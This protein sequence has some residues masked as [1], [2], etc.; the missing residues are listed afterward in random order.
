[1]NPKNHLKAPNLHPQSC[2]FCICLLLIF[3]ESCSKSTNLI[4]R[5]IK[6]SSQKTNIWANCPIIPNP[7]LFGQ[8]WGLIPLLNHR[9]L[10]WACPETYNLW[11]FCRS[12]KFLNKKRRRT[13]AVSFGSPQLLGRKDQGITQIQWDTTSDLAVG[14][15]SQAPFEFSLGKKNLGKRANSLH[16]KMGA[17]KTIRSFRFGALRPIFRGVLML[18]SGRVSSWPE[19]FPY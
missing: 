4:C 3:C 5:N 11:G 13:A 19:T 15:P 14:S 18:V 1:M 17:W 10:G 12:I 7:E 16:L 2:C 9:H 8:F 6:L